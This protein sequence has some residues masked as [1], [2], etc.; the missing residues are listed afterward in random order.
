[1]ARVIEIDDQPVAL[2][3]SESVDISFF[4]PCYN[5]EHTVAGAIEKLVRV[6]ATLGLTYE[7]LVFDD[8]SKDRT[9]GVVKHYQELCPD[10]PVSLYTNPVNRGVSRN[11]VEG[12]FRAKGK[13]YRL[14]CGDDIEPVESHITL[15]RRMGDADIIIPY[16]T[17][18]DGRK[19]Y[20]HAISKLYTFFVN[21]FSGYHLKYYNGC[22]IYRRRDILRFHVEA[23]GF[24]YQAEFLT[25]LLH[26]GRSYVEVPLISMDREGGTSLSLRNFISVAHTLLKIWLRRLRVYLFK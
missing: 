21:C 3:E 15:L 13:H 14:V 26:E 25:R 19:L 2:A 23:T 4:V 22:P 24:G 8:C 9:V 7:I 17:R 20:R 10:I 6:A 18:I 5:E 16:F 11:F 12:A 1:M